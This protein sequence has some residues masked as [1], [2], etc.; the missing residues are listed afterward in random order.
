MT[1]TDEYH[2]WL[3]AE[4]KNR[5]WHFHVNCSLAKLK[6]KFSYL[7]LE[8]M[9]EL[10]N[11]LRSLKDEE[12][13]EFSRLQDVVEE[14]IAINIVKNILEP[15]KTKS[16]RSITTTELTTALDLLQGACLVHHTSKKVA[17]LDYNGLDWMIEYMEGANLSLQLAALDVILSFMV[18]N[19]DVQAEF[20]NRKGMAKMLAMLKK[21]D[22]KKEVRIK[23]AQMLV[24]I[25]RYFSGK[26][27]EENKK[28]VIKGLGDKVASSIKDLHVGSAKDKI[29]KI[30]AWLK[31]I[32]G[33]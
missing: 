13:D 21:K 4:K 23:I 32:D 31:Q 30:D 16:D 3:N 14:N 12:Y 10:L 6:S 18:D 17:A 27:V 11:T 7:R 26:S 25:T 9:T 2:A 28:E 5:D 29:E 24:F 20:R 15:S 19:D 33:K 8:G 22:E 1:T